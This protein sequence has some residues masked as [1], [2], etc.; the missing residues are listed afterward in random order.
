[1]RLLIFLAV[2]GLA[3]IGS[4]TAYAAPSLSAI[5][6]YTPSDPGPSGEA[7]GFNKCTDKR[8][9][10]MEIYFSAK[11]TGDV[12]VI[13]SR[14]TD[15]SDEDAQFWWQV[16][17]YPSSELPIRVEGIPGHPDEDGKEYFVFVKSLEKPATQPGMV[18][19]VANH[20]MCDTDVL[21]NALQPLGES[22][23]NWP[24]FVVLAFC[25]TTLVL[26][27]RR[28]SRRYRRKRGH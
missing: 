5:H 8:E 2:F 9:P 27:L 10:L 6:M 23:Q 26:L 28:P 14:S 18:R 21:A 7:H 24:W 22:R 20:E 25:V 19:L 16:A 15:L 17:V 13:A 11:G 1:M 3:A 4:G 12:E